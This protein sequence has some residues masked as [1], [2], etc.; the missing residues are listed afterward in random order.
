MASDFRNAT[1]AAAWE[2]VRKHYAPACRCRC[3]SG[4]EFCP[5]CDD[6]RMFKAIM[7]EADDKEKETADE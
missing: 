2:I 3:P 1:L 4:K 7:S 5:A 6:A